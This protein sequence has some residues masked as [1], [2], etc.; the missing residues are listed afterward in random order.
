MNKTNLGSS[1]KKYYQL[2]VATQLKPFPAYL[3]EAG[4]EVKYFIMLLCIIGI[5]QQQRTTA[6][7]AMIP[8]NNVHKI[9]N[10]MK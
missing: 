7:T 2:N 3:L 8:E 4:L 1:P 5:R 6:F 9:L 10:Y